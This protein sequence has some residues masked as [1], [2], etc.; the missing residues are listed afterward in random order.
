MS[1]TKTAIR[2]WKRLRE[3]ITTL[4]FQLRERSPARKIVRAPVVDGIVE[5]TCQTADNGGI[6][7]V[8]DLPRFQ[9]QIE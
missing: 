8:T 2:N 3:L 9:I 5:S 6:G 4:S 7:D 1:P